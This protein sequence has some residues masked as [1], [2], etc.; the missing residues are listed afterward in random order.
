MEKYIKKIQG[1]PRAHR[2]RILLLVSGGLTLLVVLFW[3]KLFTMQTKAPKN[4]QKVESE[5][6]P[7]SVLFD[8]ISKNYHSVFDK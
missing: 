6:K 7:F 4:T 1:Q 8:S 5:F 3:I 2:Q